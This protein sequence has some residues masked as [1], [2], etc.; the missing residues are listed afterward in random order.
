MVNFDGAGI[1]YDAGLS[2][3]VRMHQRVGHE[4]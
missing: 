2:S 3:A 1:Y 4:L